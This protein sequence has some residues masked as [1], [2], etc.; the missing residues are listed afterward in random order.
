M[1]EACLQF[2]R[3][4][5]YHHV[6]EHGGMQADVVLELR[7]LHLAGNRKLTVTLRGAWAKETSQP[8]STVTH[9]LQQGHTS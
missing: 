9:F 3:L 4:V 1:E 2:Q 7:V 6:G 8:T 5:C